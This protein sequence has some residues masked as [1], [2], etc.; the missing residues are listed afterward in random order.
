M[1]TCLWARQQ[2]TGNLIQVIFTRKS[3]KPLLTIHHHSR[4]LSRTPRDFSGVTHNGADQVLRENLSQPVF[5]RVNSAHKISSC[6]VALLLTNSSLAWLCNS[7]C[8]KH[9]SWKEFC[10]RRLSLLKRK[11]K[12][13]LYSEN[14]F[15]SQNECSAIGSVI[16]EGGEYSG[17]LQEFQ[18][19]SRSASLG[20]LLRT[21]LSSWLNSEVFKCHMRQ[22]GTLMFSWWFGG[23]LI[24]RNMLVPVQRIAT[25]G[26]KPRFV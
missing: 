4:Y 26:N 11:E 20:T 3:C 18:Q 23:C 1:E 9:L 10:D 8:T 17:S 12:K 14:S 22:T 16:S 5:N 19:A 6:L 2:Q 21:W 15:C 13:I 7:C 24:Y 25:F